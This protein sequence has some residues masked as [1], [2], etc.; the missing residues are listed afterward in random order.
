MTADFGI[1]NWGALEPP[2]PKEHRLGKIA[3]IK[4]DV[5]KD[6]IYT[7]TREYGIYSLGRFACWKQTL[8]DDVVDDCHVIHRLISAEGKRSAYHQSLAVAGSKH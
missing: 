2:T 1:Y 7:M 3:P 5:R 4:D 6:F 8:L